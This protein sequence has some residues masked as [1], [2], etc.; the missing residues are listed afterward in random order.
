MVSGPKFSEGI[1]GSKAANYPLSVDNIRTYSW[2]V[3]KCYYRNI[4]I[5]LQQLLLK[6]THT[7]R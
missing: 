7:S 5:N 3:I 6:Y 2:R 1:N 4:C